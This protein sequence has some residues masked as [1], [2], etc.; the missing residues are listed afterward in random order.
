MLEVWGRMSRVRKHRKAVD[1]SR[2]AVRPRSAST[3]Q[4]R[5]LAS[6]GFGWAA[7]VRGCTTL[8]NRAPDWHSYQPARYTPWRGRREKKMSAGAGPLSVAVFEKHVL[9]T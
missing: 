9:G 6:F 2:P 3:C 8:K 7:E 1:E 5:L 4:K